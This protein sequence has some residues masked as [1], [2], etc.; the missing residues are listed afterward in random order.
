MAFFEEI[1]NLPGYVSAYGWIPFVVV[2]LVLLFCESYFYFVKIV[3]P[4][5]QSLSFLFFN[6]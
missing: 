2:I 1:S 4:I 6:L 3:S 5:S